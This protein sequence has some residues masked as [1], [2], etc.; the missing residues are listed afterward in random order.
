M[1]LVL[2]FPVW[3]QRPEAGQPLAPSEASDLFVILH[4]CCLFFLLGCIA[5]SA[6][7]I[8]RRNYRPP[9]HLQLVMELH[10]DEDDQEEASPSPQSTSSSKE[11]PAPEPW[12]KPADWWKKD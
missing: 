4:L 6:W 3:L 5:T 7:I 1:T 9:P 8:W 2:A 11:S 10:Y 12:E